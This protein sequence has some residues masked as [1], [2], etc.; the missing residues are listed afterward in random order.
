MYAHDASDMRKPVFDSITS[1]LASASSDVAAA[2]QRYD[3]SPDAAGIEH[4]RG[5]YPYT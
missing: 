2:A 5:F 1:P 3:A 4:C